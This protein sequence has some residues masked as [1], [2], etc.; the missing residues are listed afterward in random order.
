MP[1]SFLSLGGLLWFLSA[2]LFAGSICVF[3]KSVCDKQANMIFF[4]SAVLLYNYFLNTFGTVDVGHQQI[5]SGAVMAGVMAGCVIRD[6]F[7]R[8][9]AVRF[10]KVQVLFSRFI[11]VFGAAGVIAAA[12]LKVKTQLIDLKDCGSLIIFCVFLCC[13]S[14][15]SN[16]LHFAGAGYIDSLCLPVYAFQFTLILFARKINTGAAG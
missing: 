12:S 14:Y 1:R 6:L 13:T 7:N 4:I 2:A 3:L 9:N 15:H 8:M 10:N 5:L 11:L 16:V